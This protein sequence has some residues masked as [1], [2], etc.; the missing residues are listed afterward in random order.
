MVA[1]YPD[2]K[3]ILTYREPDAWLRSVHN[4]IAKELQKNDD[5]IFYVIKYFD[6]FLWN[7]NRMND[8]FRR[9]L[10]MGK[11]ITNDEAA[12]EYYRAQ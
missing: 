12:L 6:P 8:V 3:F 4:T 9:V 5:A 11:D 1:A 10:W 7:M 2:A